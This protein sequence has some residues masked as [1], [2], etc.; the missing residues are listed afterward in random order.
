MFNCLR[1]QAGIELCVASHGNLALQT[2]KQS[3]LGQAY[4]MNTASICGVGGSDHRTNNS[5]DWGVR[6]TE[7]S[8]ACGSILRMRLWKVHF[9]AGTK[10]GRTSRMP[11]EAEH[12]LD[13][14]GA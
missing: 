5:R 1:V 4:P 2:K 14:K 9:N 8:I 12:R 7:L 6:S 10:G 11:G 13:L 3:Y